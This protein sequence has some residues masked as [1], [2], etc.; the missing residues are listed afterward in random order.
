VLDPG[1]SVGSGTL[2]IIARAES[3]LSRHARDAMAVADPMLAASVLAMRGIG[4]PAPIA[5]LLNYLSRREQIADRHSWRRYPW[6]LGFRADP[7]DAAYDG[8]RA[9]WHPREAFWLASNPT[10]Y[11]ARIMAPSL[12]ALHLQLW[13]EV[14]LGGDADLAN[15]AV[16]LL[17]RALPVA[18]DDVAEWIAADDPWRD[19]FAIWQLSAHPLA[20]SHLRDLVQ[21][22]ANRYGRL[23]VRDGA[24][25]GRRFPFFREPLTSASAHLGLGLWRVGTYPRV[26]PGL[27][28]FVKA[29]RRPDGGWQDGSQPR[30]VL[31]TL[32]AAELLTAL[33]PSFDPFP[34]VRFFARRQEPTG[35]W[36]ALGPEVPWLT[37][38]IVDWMRRATGPF[39]RR[40]TWPQVA[41]AVRDRLT[42]LATI[43]FFDE[44]AMALGNL[45][46]LAR[47]PVEF[48]FI[49]LAGFGEFNTHHGQVA[50]DRALRLYAESLQRIPDALVIRDGGD[51]IL[52]IG[53]PTGRTLESQVD[54]FM[55][56]WPDRAVQLQIARGA[57]V[58]RVVMTSV[59][60]GALHEAR[61]TL[62]Q[63][64]GWLKQEVPAP[65]P[66]G[67]KRRI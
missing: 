40:F 59:E 25:H 31:T 34:T 61:N 54:E 28:A 27:Y 30:D 57:V 47:L 55:R 67:V 14:A 45:P 12:L 42:G 11:A 46:E 6:I 38:S 5:P 49:D 29:M 8:Q 2:P 15:R 22:L 10:Q 9:N 3:A 56:T 52:V 43:A 7:G 53:L 26:L 1:E 33:D 23:A 19:T 16:Q 21:A 20:L 17:R 4:N 18:E 41:P 51:E 44:L 35:W 64:I 60:A 32:A 39:R 62:G 50:G 37:A 24:V 58:P 36:R 13:S 63:A 66:E 48:A 65:G